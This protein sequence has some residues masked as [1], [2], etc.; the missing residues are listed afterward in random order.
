[1]KYSSKPIILFYTCTTL[2]GKIKRIFYTINYDYEM[3][4]SFPSI[5]EGIAVRFVVKSAAVR[6]G[7]SINHGHFTVLVNILYN[8]T[9]LLIDDVHHTSYD[10]LPENLPDVQFFILEKFITNIQSPTQK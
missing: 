1:M 6:T 8:K 9:W 5:R 3:N 2:M 4:M 10:Q 7:E